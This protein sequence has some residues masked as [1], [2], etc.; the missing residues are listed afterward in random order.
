MYK[1]KE[2][3]KMCIYIYIYIYIKR[4]IN[5]SFFSFSIFYFKKEIRDK[6][7]INKKKL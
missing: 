4:D 3:I 7:K 2:I 6:N 5:I 1:K